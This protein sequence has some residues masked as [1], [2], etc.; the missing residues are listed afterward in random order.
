MTSWP[1][2]S[3]VGILDH[4]DTLER[5]SVKV[6]NASEQIRIERNGRF[7]GS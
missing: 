3:E 4:I 1:L 7:E 5:I 6:R 2:K